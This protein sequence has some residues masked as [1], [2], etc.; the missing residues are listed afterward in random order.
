MAGPIL[1]F[2]VQVRRSTLPRVADIQSATQG[3]HD[4]QQPLFLSDSQPIQIR[5]SVRVAAAVKA[6]VSFSQIRCS[7]AV[8]TLSAGPGLQLLVGHANNRPGP[9]KRFPRPRDDPGGHVLRG[10]DIR[11]DD[12]E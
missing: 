11:L 5:R 9:S 7:G 2:T 8:P 6:V 4:S 10:E 1:I 3:R 12:L